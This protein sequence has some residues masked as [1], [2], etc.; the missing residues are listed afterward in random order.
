MEEGHGDQRGGDHGVDMEIAVGVEGG[1]IPPN[2]VFGRSLAP[3]NTEFLCSRHNDVGNMD[4]TNEV[5]N[6]VLS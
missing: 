4:G 1:L 6:V 5:I 3:P 2:S